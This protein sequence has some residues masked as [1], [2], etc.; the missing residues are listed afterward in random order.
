MAES[1]RIVSL[2]G[3]FAFEFAWSGICI[4]LEYADKAHIACVSDLKSNFFDTEGGCC[5]ELDC[6]LDSLL[7]NKL[8]KALPISFLKYFG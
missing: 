8:D 4:L 1:I 6:F 3:M 7:I 2:I 5:D